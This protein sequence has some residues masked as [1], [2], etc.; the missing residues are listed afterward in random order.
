VKTIAGLYWKPYKVV[1]RFAIANICR[2][3]SLSIER[4]VRVELPK[5][6]VVEE[7][8]SQRLRIAALG[9]EHRIAESDFALLDAGTVMCFAAFDSAQLAGFIWVATGHVSSDINHDGKPETGLPIWLDDDTVFIF[10]A[11]VFPNYR[12]HQLYAALVTAAADQ[13]QKRGIRKIVL[14]TEA[15]NIL[16]LSAVK[17]MGFQQVGQSWLLRIG[18]FCKASYPKIPANCGMQ[19]GRYVGDRNCERSHDS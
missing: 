17:R 1:R 3:F 2:F 15:S 7:C 16:A 6:I 9:S 8:S 11:L 4:L 5:T 12:G 10:Q 18:P 13:L 14:T 19:I